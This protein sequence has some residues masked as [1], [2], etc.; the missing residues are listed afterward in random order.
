MTVQQY[1]DLAW[2]SI[3]AVDAAGNP[4]S[5]G[6][7]AFYASVFLTAM[8]DNWGLWDELSRTDA[9]FK[10]LPIP[11]PD[12]SDPENINLAYAQHYMIGR[13]M[14]ANTGDLNGSKEII[15]AYENMK[16]VE[17]FLH[18]GDNMRTDPRHPPSPPSEDAAQ[19]GVKGVVQGVKDWESTHPGQKGE[20]GDSRMFMWPFI[21]NTLKLPDNTPNVPKLIRQNSI[22]MHNSLQTILKYFK[23]M[24]KGINVNFSSQ[25]VNAVSVMCMNSSD[26]LGADLSVQGSIISPVS[27]GG[28]SGTAA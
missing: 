24:F 26:D 13:Y 25:S 21:M 3:A 17:F 18:A 4:I 12:A 14:A 2:N 15:G 19:W 9:R 1:I 6:D 7:R 28:N 8:R 27:G 23:D 10:A 11:M 20:E 5:L 22:N 16:R